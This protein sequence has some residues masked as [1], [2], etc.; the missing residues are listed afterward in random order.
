[1]NN[2]LDDLKN[3]Y[4]QAG[5]IKI[6]D[7]HALEIGVRPNDNVINISLYDIGKIT[8]H[9]CPITTSAFFI[10]KAALKALY[11]EGIPSRENFMVALSKYSDLSLVISFILDAFP[12][13]FDDDFAV[14]KM[15][16]DKNLDLGNSK[17]KFIFKRI[18]TGKTIAVIW[19]KSVTV[20]KEV[21]EK[22]AYYKNF[23]IR[24][25]YEYV[26]HLKWNT[27]VNKHVEKIITDINQKML[28]IEDA[29]DYK[30]PGE[31]KY[32]LI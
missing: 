12:R 4:L 1:M 10:T 30:F 18:D 27:F 3:T 16:L 15:F 9:I 21:A 20:P 29:D 23:K 7:P 28:T 5:Y 6:Y 17:F 26:D 25:K 22:M 31:M 14:S 19:D 8:G 11:P 2:F 32:N 13:P 24:E